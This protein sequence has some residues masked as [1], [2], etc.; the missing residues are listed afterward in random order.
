M[1]NLENVGAI[2][3]YAVAAIV[4]QA[5]FRYPLL[6]GRLMPYAMA[7]V[8]LGYSEFNDRKPSGAGVKID[9]NPYGVSGL[10]GVGIEYFVTSNIAFNF[11]TRYLFSRGQTIQIDGGSERDGNF[12]S[13]LFSLGLRVFF[14]RV[15]Q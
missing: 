12:D 13:V 3:E 5:R 4:P 14:P 11:E 7:G 6:E 2:G 10:L 9:G 15:W 1:L 8:G